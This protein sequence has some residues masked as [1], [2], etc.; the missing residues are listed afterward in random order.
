MDDNRIVELYWQRDED[1]IKETK[2]KYGKYCYAIAYNI[3]SDREDAEEC[4]NDTYLEAWQS[5]PPEKPDPLRGFLGM[6]SRRISLDRWRKR[7]AAKRGGGEISL[8]FDEL[9]ECIPY[10]KSIDEELAAEELAKLISAFLENLS[11][12]EGNV[13]LRRYFYF[14]SINDICQRYGFGQSKVKMM[15]KRTREKLLVRL[16][17]EGIFI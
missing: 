16:T 5:M 10:G 15:L 17:E 6:L 1:A 4:E 11:E 7:H 9:E 2:D 13:F 8:S 3:L 12:M 14:D